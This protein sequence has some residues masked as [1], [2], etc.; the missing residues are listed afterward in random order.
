M[1]RGDSIIIYNILINFEALALAVQ[2]I[3]SHFTLIFYYYLETF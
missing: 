3:K 1:L 2:S